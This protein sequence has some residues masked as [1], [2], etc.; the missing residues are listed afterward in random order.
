MSVRFLV[1]VTNAGLSSVNAVYYQQSATVI[2]Q[3]FAAVCEQQRWNVQKTWDKLNAG[4]DWWY[5]ENGSYIYANAM[6]GKWWIDEPNGGGVYIAPAHTGTPPS[7]GWQPLM[8][9]VL[10]LP[11]VNVEAEAVSRGAQH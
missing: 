1:T 2:P 4:R 7:E 10:P 8:K 6:D 9:N 3:G 11:N 5:A